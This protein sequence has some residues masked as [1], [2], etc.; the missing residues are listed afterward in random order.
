MNI[1]IGVIKV[2]AISNIGS[3]N[4][5]K[6][7]LCNNEAVETTVA[8]EETIADG[9]QH[10][11][12]SAG[13]APLAEPA[14]AEAPYAAAPL[15]PP[16]WSAAAAP[17]PMPTWSAAGS[18]PGLPNAAPAAF[19]A[20]AWQRSSPVPPIPARSVAPTPARPIAPV[21]EARANPRS[22]RSGGDVGNRQD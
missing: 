13:E 3:L 8:A 14:Y 18:P 22:S 10:A 1:T 6:T 21:A 12:E 15:P 19:P 16:P 9:A 7:I 17:A 11:E 20:D 2:N 4:I 5:G